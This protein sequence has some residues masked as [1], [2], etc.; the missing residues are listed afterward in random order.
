MVHVSIIGDTIM[1]RDL[2]GTVDR[3]C[4]DAPAPVF[5]TVRSTARAG[6]AGLAATSARR[7]HGENLQVSLVSAIAPD[8]AGTELREM[9]AAD[10]VSLH[11]IGV[12]GETVE[13]T[14]V[15]CDGQSLV[16]LDSGSGAAVGEVNAGAVEALE[17]CDAIL[18]ADYGL[19]ITSAPTVRRA[20]EAAIGRG[21]PVVWDPHP[22]GTAPVSRVSVLTPNRSEARTTA[23]ELAGQAA[24][25]SE[26]IEAL[27]DAEV[28][29]SA[30][31][32]GAVCVTLGSMGSVTV[33]GGAPLVITPRRSLRNVDTCGAGDVFASSLA[34]GLA[35]GAVLSEALSGAMDKVADFL[36]GGD[37][38]ALT[39]DSA[40]ALSQA[41]QDV[42]PA[43]V[44][45][46]ATGG[47]FDLLHTGHIAMLRAA[48]ALGDR[49]VVLLNSDASVKRLKGSDRPI[50]GED[51]R[52]A[53]LRS[54]ECVDEVIIFDEDTPVEALQ[55]L[56]PAVFVK[57]GDYTSM[58][59]VE[60]KVVGSW[61][62]VAVTVPFLPGY[63][64][65]EIVERIAQHST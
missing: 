6:G 55:R 20:I 47:C 58:D 1:D 42:D 40:D 22:R 21:V 33:R 14:R 48:R 56:K 16:R 60:S 62:G 8:D 31:D 4:P 30:F 44:S 53:T 28:L 34:I 3:I 7:L 27:H 18:V 46:V 43:G 65:T 17:T 36:S 10:G 23:K 24:S 39:A 12:G 37:H 41:P 52:A 32:C 57:G 25:A 59:L 9:L 13:K 64:T 51:D 61:G 2:I 50:I 38:D 45:T 26:L 11:D 15:R 29:R 63:S 49:L 35:R 54:L 19:G 5:D